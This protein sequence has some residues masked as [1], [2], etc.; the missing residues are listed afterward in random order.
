MFIVSAGETELGAL[1][2]VNSHGKMADGKTGM[3]SGACYQDVELTMSGS[4][5][6]S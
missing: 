2:G 5:G 6:S 3:T 1:L 4:T